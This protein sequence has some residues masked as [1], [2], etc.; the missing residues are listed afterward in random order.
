MH[1]CRF[2]K[3]RQDPVLILNGSAIPVVEETKFLGIIFDRKLSFLPHIRHL[4][5]KYT[6]A[7]SR[8]ANIDSSIEI[9]HQMETRLWLCC[10]WLCSRL[11]LTHLGSDSKSWI[12]SLLWCLSNVAIF[13]FICITQWTSSLHTS[14]AAI[15]AV[16]SKAIFHCS[17]SSI[18][19]SFCWQI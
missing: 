8:S 17:K 14:E 2:H 4:K 9:P 11:L 16:L 7:L 10:L 3:L 1:F 15:Y 6:K 12:S 13:Q 5:G 19:W 18:Q